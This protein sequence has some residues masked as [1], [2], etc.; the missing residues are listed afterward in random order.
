MS[1]SNF[2]VWPTSS[3]EKETGKDENSLIFIM[4]LGHAT[5]TRLK[6]LANSQEI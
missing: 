3:R 2:T 4:L 1:G 5:F 6:D